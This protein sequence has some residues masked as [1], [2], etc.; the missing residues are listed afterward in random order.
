[1]NKTARIA[2]VI[3]AIGIAGFL[4]G[5]GAYMLIAALKWMTY[6][7]VNY[8]LAAAVLFIF[9][10]VGLIAYVIPKIAKK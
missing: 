4:F 7:N 6:A 8:Y 10:S 2:V 9:G 5:F 3:V 1:M